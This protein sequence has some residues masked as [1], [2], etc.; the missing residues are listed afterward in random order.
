MN[1]TKRIVVIDDHT[2]FLKGLYGILSTEF[3]NSDIKCFESI[4]DCKRNNIDFNI[5][6]LF[7][8]D[9]ELPGEDIFVFL[10]LTKKNHPELPVLVLTMHKKLSVIRKCKNLEISGY[11]LKDDDDLFTEA[12]HEVIIGKKFYSPRIEKLY[13]LYSEQLNSLS[14]REEE[15]LKMIS[16]GFSNQEMAATLFVSVETV[17]SHKKNIK[18]KLGLTELSDLVQYAQDN[19]LI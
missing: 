15:I 11:L 13:R 19:Y 5:I 6:D 16:Q 10:E 1:K 18:L 3:V 14:P 7:I 9:I 2:L 12:L 17:K 8:S 4:N